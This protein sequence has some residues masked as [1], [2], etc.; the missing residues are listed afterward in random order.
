MIK[1]LIL[2][3]GAVSVVALASSPY[4]AG[5]AVE[6]QF[7]QQIQLLKQQPGMPPEIQLSIDS[8][9]RGYLSSTAYTSF[10]LNL[11]VSAA[12]PAQPPLSR[13]VK[14]TMKHRIQHGPLVADSPFTITLARFVSTFEL[15]DDLSAIERAYFDETPFFQATSYL[16]AN[17]YSAT[18]VEI[19]PYDGPSHDGNATIHWAG[20]T[21]DS[22]GKWADMAGK[23]VLSAPMLEIS[24]AGN[25]FVLTGLRG[26]ADSRISPLGLALGSG[27]FT[28]DEAQATGTMANGA[29][30]SISLHKLKLF[31]SMDE[32]EQIFAA[33]EE[34]GFENFMV[35]DARYEKGVLRFEF[36]NIDAPTL[37]SM[38]EKFQ[39]AF[40]GMSGKPDPMAMQQAWMSIMQEALPGLLKHS[41]E[42]LVSKV[43]LL[44]PDGLINGRL[45]VAIENA[46]PARL[47]AGLPALIPFINIEIDL[48][49]PVP[50][51]Q[52]MA[53]SAAHDQLTA[54][55]KA[56]KT[57][58][59]EAEL[60]KK[61]HEAAE[62]MLA[63]AEKQNIIK[64]VDNNYTASFRFRQGQIELNGLPAQGLM[65]MLPG[66]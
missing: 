40:A 14:V 37:K 48:S 38:Q 52:E 24:Q 35:D 36:N 60:E 62:Q 49:V 64:H 41:P 28:I 6:R 4:W 18:H 12:Q 7:E 19:P 15:N 61:I 29:P 46:D 5:M 20:L 53:R 39:V 10:T 17:G 11:P 30:L 43:E 44:T 45:K 65:N 3:I 26:N 51:I 56:S 9:E 22:E 57:E 34:I 58:V 63:Q 59:D 66:A 2:S 50:I 32:K 42:F 54:R 21:L 31:F 47:S 13:P 16:S 23:A 55:L 33:A 25:R 1:K 27:T 8:Y